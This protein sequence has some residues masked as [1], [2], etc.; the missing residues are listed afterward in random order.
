[1]TIFKKIRALPAIAVLGAVLC[2]SSIASADPI[3]MVDFEITG[4]E[5]A[6][7][8]GWFTGDD[9]IG[10]ISGLLAGY[11]LTAFELVWS[12]NATTPGFEHG[13]S[14]LTSFLYDIGGNTLLFLRSS[15]G[16]GSASVNHLFASVNGPELRACF[17]CSDPDKQREWHPGITTTIKVPEPGTL[18]LFAIGLLAVGFASRRRLV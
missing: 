11:E 14:D 9:S 6:T 8:T 17:F 1:M 5:D 16:D 2:W 12:G 3:V 13:L 4:F 18:T 10:L 15:S 7:L